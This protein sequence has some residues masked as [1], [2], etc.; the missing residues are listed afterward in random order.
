VNADCQVTIS[1]KS[2]LIL[3]DIDLL[4]N[5]KQLKVALSINTLDENF[6]ADMDKGSTIDRRKEAL[7]MLH[8][9]GIYT[10]LFMSPIFPYITEYEKIIEQTKEFVNEYWFENLNLRGSNKKVIMD[11]I[12]DSHPQLEEKYIDIYNNKNQDYWKKLTSELDAIGNRENIKYINYF[13]HEELVKNKKES[14]R[15]G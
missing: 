9:E 5:M 10:V 6:R 4:K 7:K 8:K 13:Y 11:Y 15:N 1:T 3:R 2:D 12:R 14:I